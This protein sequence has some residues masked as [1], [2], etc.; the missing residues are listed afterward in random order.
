M[1]IKALCSFSAE[2]LRSRNS[3]IHK[4]ILLL[5]LLYSLYAAAAAA[6][7]W[8]LDMYDY[9]L[10]PLLIWSGAVFIM[11]VCLAVISAGG[12]GAVIAECTSLLSL[13]CGFLHRARKRLRR[14][15]FLRGIA[16]LLLRLSAYAVIAGAVWLIFDAVGR[17][18]AIYH[19]FGALQA[20]PLLIFL[21]VLKF[22]TESAFAASEVLCVQSPE[23]SSGRNFMTA[24]RMLRGQYGFVFLL[25]LRKLPSLLLPVTQPHLAMAAVSCFS[26]RHLEWKYAQKGAE[27]EAE[28]THIYRRHRKA[29]EAGGLSPA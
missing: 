12:R 15:Y 16:R 11:R 18:E 6:G 23:I 22:R 7:I 21:L 26:V 5:M 9:E 19:L 2:T 27:T 4:H 8:L 13:P 24:C 17:D 29:N 3:A 28:H 14:L 1:K 20:V 10:I 25:L